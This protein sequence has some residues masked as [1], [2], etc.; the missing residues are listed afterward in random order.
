MN[1]RRVLIV[2]DE[3]ADWMIAGLR[4]LDRL[5][6]SI[7]EFAVDNNETAPVL[8]CILWRADLDESQRWVPVHPRLTKVAFTSDLDGQ[9]YDLVLSTRLFLYRKAIAVLLEQAVP[10]PVSQP[11]SW[12]DYSNAAELREPSRAG[13]WEQIAN[14]E[15]IDDIERKFLR[16][17][18]KSQDG[19]V[20]RHLNRP[21]SRAITR[22][23]LRLPA[24]P[25]GWTWLIFPIPVVAA[26]VLAQ[27]NY[28]SFVWGLI[29]FQ[30]FSILDGCDGEIA[31]AKFMESERG[32]QLDDLFDVLSNIL[33]VVGLAIGLRQA[34]PRFGWL[35]LAEGIV[36]A[37]LIA[38]NEWCLARRKPSPAVESKHDSLGGALYPRH[39]EL[40]ER[41][42]LLVFGEK[43]ASV[44][45]QTTKR[46]VAVL[47]FVLLAVLGIPALIL[48]LLFLVTA[49]TLAFALKSR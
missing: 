35:F 41:S 30:V 42:G 4:Q 12:E 7:D 28:W 45:I 29:L 5:A 46:D 24:T 32:R 37:G 27:G 10:P 13:A 23:F 19:F 8:V 38:L 40:V 9:P 16:A 31:R 11:P 22:L 36:A 39:R 14:G 26:F 2:A 15:Q 21:I 43:F 6:L 20:S 3:S 47:F 48:H 17:S 34:H 25:N 49:F 1:L 44:L 33:L 18:G